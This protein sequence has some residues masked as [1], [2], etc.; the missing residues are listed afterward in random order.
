MYIIVDKDALLQYY[1]VDDD[2]CSML[3]SLCKDMAT[4]QLSSK[5]VPR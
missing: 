2:G 5:Y 3:Y 1:V 4:E